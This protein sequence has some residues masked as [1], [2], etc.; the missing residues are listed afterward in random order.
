[1]VHIR[2][3]TAAAI[4]TGL[5]LFASSSVLANSAINETR[6]ARLLYC[7]NEVSKSA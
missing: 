3:F 7:Q 1:M 5:M 6:Q 2:S 4:A